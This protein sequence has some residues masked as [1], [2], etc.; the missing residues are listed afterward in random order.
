M[1]GSTTEQRGPPFCKLVH[2]KKRKAQGLE[3]NKIKKYMY[4]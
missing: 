3:K 1:R 4:E 2:L